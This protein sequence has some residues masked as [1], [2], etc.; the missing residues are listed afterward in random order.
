VTSQ[1]LWSR[2]HDRI[3]ISV[4]N[5]KSCDEL[6]GEYLSCFSNQVE[7]V[8]LRKCPCGHR[9]TDKAHLS[10]ISMTDIAYLWVLPTRWRQKS[11]GID[12]EQNYVIVALCIKVADT[13]LPSVGFRSWSWFLAVSLRVTWVINPAVGC[14]YFPPGL[15]LPPQ[16]LRG[17]L[18]ISLL[19]EAMYSK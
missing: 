3:A 5:T 11:T 6:N 18:P 4:Y 8:S 13:R 1:S 2:G 15:Q 19:G 17:L 7:S 14:H 16:P 10:A 12:M 9:L